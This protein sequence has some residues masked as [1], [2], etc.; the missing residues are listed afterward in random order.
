MS[1]EQLEKSVPGYKKENSDYYQ[2]VIISHME[3]QM[4]LKTKKL[5][6]EHKF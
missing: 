5:K 6:R 1:S 2:A 4:G 3:D